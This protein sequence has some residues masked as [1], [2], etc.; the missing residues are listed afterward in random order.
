MYVFREYLTRWCETRLYLSLPPVFTIRLQKIIMNAVSFYGVG[1]QALE[2][3]MRS[4]F[5]ISFILGTFLS[6]QK[7]GPQIDQNKK[8]PVLVVAMDLSFPPFEG[9]DP[10]GNAYGISVDMARD[11]AQ[12]LGREAEILNVKWE[13]LI[14]GLRSGQY[15]AVI[16]SMSVTPE[17]EQVIDFSIPYGRMGID[18]ITR[19]DFSFETAAQFNTPDMRLAVRKGT[20]GETVAMRDYPKAKIVSLNDFES[21]VLE[22]L[23][24]KADVAL[25]DPL[26]VY[27]YQKKYADRLAAHY[28]SVNVVPLAI[29]VRKTEDK[30]FLSQINTFLEA[31]IV[32]GKLD[33]LTS[34][35]LADIK[36]EF[37][38]QNEPFFIF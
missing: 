12:A 13:G 24:N 23:Q 25:A 4:F 10:A 36:A 30:E 15:D 9:I 17:R 29:A 28:R 19:K 20:I 8:G 31:Y 5:I 37:K 34:E 33:A 14:P 21:A 22:V 38:K 11:L 27:E 26:T 2:V 18:F 1:K 3:Q 32:D 7:S 16:S 35:Y 6:C